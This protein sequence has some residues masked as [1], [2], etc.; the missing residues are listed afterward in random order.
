MEKDDFIPDG[1]VEN[2][3]LSETVGQKQYHDIALSREESFSYEGYQVVRREFF[4]HIHEPS[5]TFN[6]FKISLNTAC[7]K[8]LPDVDYVQILVNSE[9]KKLAV[10]P[11]G[12][13]EKDTVLWCT[14]KG[15][16]CGPRQITCRVFF[17]KVIQLMDWNPDYRY[18]MLG[19]LIQS[20]DEQLLV[21]DLTETEVYQRVLSDNDKPRMSRAPIYPTEWQNQFGLP[22]EEHRKLLQI[23]IFD[24]YTVFGIKDKPDPQIEPVRAGQPAG[25]GNNV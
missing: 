7:L 21:F 24:G 13:D 8:Q 19:K 17:S 22:V 6:R 18:K 11:R 9:E 5:F 15:E 14:A 20:G 16:K 10:R 2:S 4:S 25:E 3:V 23:N 12:E 1:T